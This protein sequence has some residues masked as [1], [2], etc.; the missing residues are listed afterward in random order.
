ML[1]AAA[2]TICTIQNRRLRCDRFGVVCC[3]R[4]FFFSHFRLFIGIVGVRQFVSLHFFRS[5]CVS[6]FSVNLFCKKIL[7]EQA[8][9]TKLLFSFFFY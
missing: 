5:S 8:I 1:S 4:V 6:L 7:Q 2:H 3:V 9:L